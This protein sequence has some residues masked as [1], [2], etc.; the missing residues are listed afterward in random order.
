[1]GVTEWVVHP[2]GIE[3]EY[4]WIVGIDQSFTMFMESM[5]HAV[6]TGD[7]DDFEPETSQPFCGCGTCV[8]RE[9][10]AFILPK[11]VMAFE[12]GKIRVVTE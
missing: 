1:V 12:T 5:M 4:D 7:M 2:N 3:F 6:Y 10:L 9:I 11:A 8:C